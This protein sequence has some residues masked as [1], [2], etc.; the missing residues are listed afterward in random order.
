M[1]KLIIIIYGKNALDDILNINKSLDIKLSID[2]IYKIKPYIGIDKRTNWE[3]FIFQN[4]INE[5]VNETIKNY[6]ENHYK[7]QNIAK[8]NYE[9]EKIYRKHINDENNQQLNKEISDVLLK[10]HKFNDVLIICIDNLLDEDSKKAF[11][12]F[13]AFTTI[14]NQ[15]PF[16]LFLTKKETNPKVTDLFQFISNEYFDKRN[17]CALKNPAND[18]E[19]RKLNNFFIKCMNYYYQSENLDHNMKIN[20]FNILIC[21]PAGVGKSTFINQFMQEKI[22]EEGEGLSITCK[23]KHYLH[24]K[25]PIKIIDTQGFE[26]NDRIKI[27]QKY[28]EKSE[29]DMIDSN[30]NI[31]LILYFNQLRARTFFSFENDLIK[32]LVKKNKGI[33]FVLNDYSFPNKKEKLKLIEKYK[34]DLKSI[35]SSN[36]KDK[37]IIIN[38]ED[39]LNNIV[40]IK[41]KQS[42]YEN[43]DNEIKIKQN[44]GMDILLKKIYDLY[45]N[46]T[47]NVYDIDVA[48]NE[49]EIIKSIEKYKTLEYI[50]KFIKFHINKKIEASK[51]I[52]SY[53]YQDYFVWLMKNKRRNELIEKINELYE[54]KSISNI[55]EVRENFK[56][57]VDK[58]EN[59]N[60]II[61]EYLESIKNFKD[62][63][64]EDGY[65]LDS[66]NYNENTFLIGYLFLT[67][68]LNES[69]KNIISLKKSLKEYCISFNKSIN[70]F[71]ELSF[72]WEKVYQSLKEHKSDS[73]WINKFFIVEIP[74][75]IE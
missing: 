5:D 60:K 32:Y 2:D 72:E 50:H 19:V 70:I 45:S 9:I 53:S 1:E 38:T 23:L 44:Y 29:N 39:I 14:S 4:E 63:F 21:G 75:K 47:I 10:Y 64:E 8:T 62:I 24:P 73:E 27:I 59:K 18:E 41:L 34:K 40:I 20:T 52:L 17:I 31:D 56:N 7:S 49:A 71:K 65:D 3:Y 42:I 16:I 57:K 51:L 28:I 35:I 12:Y 69:N 74:E 55:D 36:E 26:S 46:N 33:I 68:F 13:Q 54:R 25:Y 48:K 11:K 43:D 6:L 67:Q 37:D 15:Q 58:I 61:K 66:S 22:A 30:H